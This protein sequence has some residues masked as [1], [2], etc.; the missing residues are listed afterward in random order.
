M[1]LKTLLREATPIRAL[2][3]KPFVNQKHFAMKNL[4]TPIKLHR[5]LKD[6]TV[7]L[8]VFFLA[9]SS[10]SFKSKIDIKDKKSASEKT[11]KNKPGLTFFHSS[12][13][14]SKPYAQLNPNVVS[15]VKKYIKVE[16]PTLDKIK[17]RGKRQFDLY[18]KILKSHGLP[19]E[20]KY[21]SV[22]ESGLTA[23]AVSV[24]GA[25][26]PWQIMQEEAIRMGLKVNATVDERTNFKKSTHAAAKIL[27]ELYNQFNDWT[28]VIAAYNCGAGRVRFAIRKS[29]SKNYWD[30]NRY[31]PLE[32]RFHVKRFIGTHYIFEGSGGVT[33]TTAA[34][35]K[36][37]N[38][39]VAEMQAK[40]LDVC[41]DL[42][43]VKL[44]NGHKYL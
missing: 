32:T 19:K 1:E 10:T 15:F 39:K 13:D 37:Y 18:D 27:K 14:S 3:Y 34:E 35:I 9:L 25:T 26:G 40:P 2:V 5:G 8:L 42:T 21:L 41:E 17:A 6:W 38:L 43:L 22:I 28:L 33:T 11:E 12:F 23:K 7:G 24:A 4:I 30:L 20:L 44:R 29:G 31:L 36:R 16:G